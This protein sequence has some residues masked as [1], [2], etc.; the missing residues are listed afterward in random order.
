MLRNARATW[1]EGFHFKARSHS[2]KEIRLD[3]WRDREREET[4]PTPAELI[5]MSLGACTG[6]D[7]IMILEKM[8]L[9]V[10]ALEVDVQAEALD[11]DP[12][13]FTDFQ[14]IYHLRGE[15]L[16][17]DKVERAI[18]LSRDKYCL[19][20]ITLEKAASLSHFYTIN[21]GEP[22]EV[23]RREIPRTN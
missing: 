15:D 18:V 8:R 12:R 2:G 11:E 16:D 17:T 7:V 20:S 14:I 5:P 22:R 9:N 4:G 23:V 21:G 1:V 6:M 19:I 10:T 13:T 3:G